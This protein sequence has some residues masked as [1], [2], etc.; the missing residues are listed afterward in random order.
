MIIKYYIV[1]YN[2]YAMMQTS[3]ALDQKTIFD[4]SFRPSFGACTKLLFLIL[5]IGIKIKKLENLYKDLT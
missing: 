1:Y 5:M 2:V 3:N 4:I